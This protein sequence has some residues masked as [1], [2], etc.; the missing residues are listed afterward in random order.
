MRRIARLMG[1]SPNTI[2]EELARNRVRGAYDAEQAQQK[3]YARKKYAKYQG[4]KIF[5]HDDLRK[6][7]HLRILD[8][9][10]PRAIARRITRR[11]KH[12]PSISRNAIYRYIGS[13]YGRRL[14]THRAWKKS[15][16]RGRRPRSK[17]LEGRTM[18]DA[19]P[20]YINDRSRLGHAEG[21]FIVS[22][23]AG[24]GILLVVVDRKSR[25]AFIEP[26]LPVTIPAME[27]A[28]LRIQH[29]YLEMRTMTT[30]NDILFQYHKRLAALL[31]IRIFFCH[32][33]R[34]SEKGGIENANKV[35]RRDIPKG[36]DISRRSRRFLEKLE[37]KLNRRPME[38]LRDYTPQ[39]VLSAY[40]KRVHKNKKRPKRVS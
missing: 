17:K 6:E 35:I 31:G 10:S 9:Q 11:E 5:E 20:A 16:R 39:E 19:R 26:I 4:K 8:D 7:I 12:L 23:K 36:A 32:P 33:Y 24:R 18:I 30:D 22:G 29:R 14:E 21:D 27:Q 25:T 15:R 38:V 2:S 28:F 40:R 3:A 34:S 1:R 13:P 37:A